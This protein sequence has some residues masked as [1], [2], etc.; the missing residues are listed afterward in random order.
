MLGFIFLES[1]KQIIKLN[2]R[3][4]SEA[5]LIKKLF[6]LKNISFIRLFNIMYNLREKNFLGE[7]IE[8]RLFCV[9]HV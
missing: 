2:I 4:N 5:T 1:T 7:N 8:N 6:I 9:I 3:K